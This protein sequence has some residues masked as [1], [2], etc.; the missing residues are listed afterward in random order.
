MRKDT[1]TKIDELLKKQEEADLKKKIEEENL[2][3]CFAKAFASTEGK[4][5]LKY[6]K[7]ISFWG[8]QDENIN[9]DVVLY[10]KGR[11]DNW[12]IIRNLIP[13]ETLAQVEIFDMDNLT[14]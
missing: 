7:K 1:Q 13:R 3:K 10:K 14:E 6:L 8:Q 4:Q 12:A 9:K 2:K 5:V 11:S